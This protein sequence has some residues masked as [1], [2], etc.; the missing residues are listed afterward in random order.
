MFEERWTWRSI[1][2]H[3]SVS[4]LTWLLTYVQSELVHLSVCEEQPELDLDAESSAAADYTIQWD[5]Q[6]SRFRATVRTGEHAGK[7]RTLHPDHIG[8]YRLAR[9]K[10]HACDQS[11]SQ[12]DAAKIFLAS[13]CKAV[14]AN[15][16]ASFEANWSDSGGGD[17]P[18]GSSTCAATDSPGDS[19]A[20]SQVQQSG[21]S[22]A[23]AVAGPHAD[24][25][26][27]SSR[28]HEPRLTQPIAVE[29]TPKHVRSRGF[30]MLITSSRG[31]NCERMRAA[32]N[33]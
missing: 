27:R 5:F 6:Q 1:P 30:T 32:S 11:L 2:I 33:Y 10:E 29:S 7:E 21:S 24:A 9:A 28:D 23:P 15:D 22:D 8:G 20:S 13:W 19:F 12:R 4:N 31:L 25:E 16:D 18:A 14:I 26:R 3:I 17:T